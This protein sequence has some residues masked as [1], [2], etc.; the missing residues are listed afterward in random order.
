LTQITSSGP[1]EATAFFS[2]ASFSTSLVQCIRGVAGPVP[3][4]CAGAAA[5]AA[6]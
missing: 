6:A 4:G 3:T 2:A 5:G 1:A